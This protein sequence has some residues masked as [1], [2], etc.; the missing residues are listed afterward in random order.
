M[1]K[2]FF[3]NLNFE[4]YA[5]FIINFPILFIQNKENYISGQKYKFI[6]FMN[7]KINEIDNRL[8]TE[9]DLSTI[10]VQSLLKID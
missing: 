4:K 9:N 8:P 1:P 2:I 5:D 7:K 10:L 3:E 6:D